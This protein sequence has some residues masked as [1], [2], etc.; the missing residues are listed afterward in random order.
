MREQ[1][2]PR[3]VVRDRSEWGQV[4]YYLRRRGQKK[5]RLP[6]DFRSPEF[7]TA[8]AEAM[9]GNVA[10]KP[11]MPGSL[12][13]IIAGSFRELTVNYLRALEADATIAARTKYT[14]RRHLEETCGETVTFGAGTPKQKDLKIGDLPVERVTTPVIQVVLDRRQ[15]TP[16]AANDKRKCLQAM[17]VW[18]VPRG[19]AKGNPIRDSLKMKNKSEGHKT[20]TMEDVDQFAERHPFGTKA[21]LALSLFLFTDQRLGDVR[22]FGRQH[23]KDGK[24]HFRQEK[25]GRP[26][27]IPILPTLQAALETVPKD[28]MTFVVTEFGKPFS[29]KGLGNWFHD[30]VVEA[31]LAE[32]KLSAHGLRKALQAL[33]PQ[34]G[35]TPFELMAIAGHASLKETTRYTREYEREMQAKSGMAKLEALRIGNKS[36]PGFVTQ[37]DAGTI[38]GKKLNDFKG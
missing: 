32:K 31:G 2:L 19:H 22:T 35:V 10:R 11:V 28:Q 21:Y 33:G 6:D 36:V 24:L 5:I 20:W 13:S 26:M 34:F 18:A 12:A 15:S 16:E 17:Y 3:Y 37:V 27:A 8:Y 29:S 7:W 38:S 23:V 9:K 4:R 14:R 30:R 25:G 1:K